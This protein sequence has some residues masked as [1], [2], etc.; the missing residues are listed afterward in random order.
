MKAE[1]LCHERKLQLAVASMRQLSNFT[2]KLPFL[3]CEGND[4]VK[5]ASRFQKPGF[6]KE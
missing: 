6:A 5:S 1:S 2:I 4:S 3:S